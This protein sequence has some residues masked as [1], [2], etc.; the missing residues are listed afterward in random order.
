MRNLVNCFVNCEIVNLN[1][2]IG[3]LFRQV[4]NIKYIDE[5]IGLDVF[6]EKFWEIVQLWIDYQEVMLKEL[7]EM[8]VSGKI[9]KLGI[10]YRLRKFDEIVEQLW[11][12]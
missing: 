4:E 12:G 3:V 5:R 10:N 7:G 1:K 9:S 2:M 6:F 11:I 8:V